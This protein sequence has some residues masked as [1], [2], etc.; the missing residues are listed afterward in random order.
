MAAGPSDIVFQGYSDEGTPQVGLNRVRALVSSGPGVRR[1]QLNWDNRSMVL[2]YAGTIGLELRHFITP[3]MVLGS[4]ESQDSSW[5]RTVV[6]I[7]GVEGD[8]PIEC[9]LFQDGKSLGPVVPLNPGQVLGWVEGE[10]PV[11]YAKVANPK[12]FESSIERPI[13]LRAAQDIHRLM[14]NV[15]TAEFQTK[16]KALAQHRSPETASL[17]IRTLCMLGDFDSLMGANNAL[18]RP[19][20]RAYWNSIIEDWRA[21]LA[22]SN[23][24]LGVAHARW[25]EADQVQAPGLERL[26]IGFSEEQLTQGADRTLYDA[27]SSNQMEYRALGAFQLRQILESDMEYLA[28]RPLPES[29]QNIRKLLTTGKLNYSSLP[30]PLPEAK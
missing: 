13:E 27:L 29:L 24:N 14:L 12:W 6:Q 16:L 4:P 11:S 25:L 17:A 23:R 22:L 9:A 10:Q 28:D 15:P 20:L 21:S 7:I 8:A 2:S 1:L 3:G 26:L 19:N 5:I 30:V 18:Q